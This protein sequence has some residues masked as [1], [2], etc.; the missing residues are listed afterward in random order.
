M[1]PAMDTAAGQPPCRALPCSPMRPR[2]LA[3]VCVL[4]AGLAA[5]GCLHRPTTVTRV[6]V[7]VAVVP[8]P[9]AIAVGA[10]DPSGPED[11]PGD[12]GR[13]G[14]GALPC[15][16][17]FGRVAPVVGVAVSE[18]ETCTRHAGGGVCCWGAWIPGQPGDDR[19][20]SRPVRVTGLPAATALGLGEGHA[21]ALDGGGR[22]H[23]W[24]DGR[25]GQM[26]DGGRTPRAAPAP[27]LGLPEVDALAVG[28]WHA[29][30]RTVDGTVR[31]WGGNLRG[32]TGIEADVFVPRAV[33]G[34]DHVAALSAGVS[35]CAVT[36]DGAVECWGDGGADFYR[37][38]GRHGYAVY[39]IPELRGV[40]QV[41]FGY[42]DGAPRDD[43]ACARMRDGAVWCWL[44]PYGAPRRV[45]GVREVTA[46]SVGG[47]HACAL[48]RDGKL[49]C[50]G[51]ND[52]GQLG[53]GTTV[54]RTRPTEVPGVAEVVEVATASDHTCALRRDA[55]LWCW[56]ANERGQ[57]GDG[58][59]TGRPAAVA[60]RW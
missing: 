41:A 59:R 28:Q 15:A 6:D 9:V 7:H 55:T 26:G 49:W 51:D 34:V 58:T 8:P 38:R 33:D 4:A 29:C 31:C 50:W 2:S 46:V 25:M 1:W 27:V 19:G 20:R 11:P 45:D 53:D 13:G 52:R 21:C 48:R 14:T 22:V 17:A 39:P 40:T 3:A 43:L 37:N 32:P 5:V 23:C 24:G 60:V 44:G 18:G 36:A 57:L 16:D 54:P 35:S 30:A 10:P 42:G 12:P 56:G 47:G